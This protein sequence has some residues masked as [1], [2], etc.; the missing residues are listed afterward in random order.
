MTLPLRVRLTIFYTVVLI[1]VLCAVGVDVWWVEGRLGLR[2]VDR[3]LEG[4]STTVTNVIRDELGEGLSV[5]S[6]AE[7]ACYMVSLPDRSI[8]VVDESG[9]VIAAC[10]DRLK[11]SAPLLPARDAEVWTLSTGA[12]RWRVR[13]ERRLFHDTRVWLVVAS[14]LRRVER[15]QEEVV[16]TM[17]VALSIV[18]LL[19]GGGGLWIATLA[20]R[21]ITEMARQATQITTTGSETLGA[22]ARRDE[23]GAFATAFNGLLAR[24][25][26]ALRT[27]REFMADASHEL[28]TPV[29]VVRTATDV[30]LG[31]PARHEGEYRET[32]SIIGT[33]AQRLSRLVD[34]MLVLARADAGGYAVQHVELYLDEIVAE[35]C[36]A[37]A[38]LCKERGVTIHGGPWPEMPFRG[39]EDLLRQLVLNVL[40]NAVQH[41]PPGGIVAVGLTNTAGSVTIAITDS[42]AGIPVADRTRIF[43]RFV[44]LD[45]ARTGSGAGLG[46][47][48]AKWIAEAHGG[49]LV[50]AD[51]GPLGSTFRIVL[52]QQQGASVCAESV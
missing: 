16:E 31:R 49:T 30:A 1:V 36:G 44:R 47:P 9:R 20:L 24:L 11:W 21:P 23:L 33:Q 6:A 27:Q 50:L 46:L 25:R 12:E 8:A 29:S 48:I 43:E 3:E 41:T 5:E 4:V 22:A 26:G 52:G 17:S 42:G 2:R 37:V 51:S 39:D 35:C 14:S 15:Q 32:L 10:W 19:A 18:F 13:A 34:S 28:R 7:E 45:A 40:Q 38:M